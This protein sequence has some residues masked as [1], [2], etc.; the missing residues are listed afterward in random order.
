MGASDR[1]GQW[2]NHG[3]PQEIVT[4]CLEV[5]DEIADVTVRELEAEIPGLKDRVFPRF[6][7]WK[8]RYFTPPQDEQPW[9]LDEYE[10]ARAFLEKHRN[11]VQV[12]SSPGRGSSG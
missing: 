11:V 4:A 2:L 1:S 5:N 10:R 3:V 7:T 9:T 8:G 6:D 12:D